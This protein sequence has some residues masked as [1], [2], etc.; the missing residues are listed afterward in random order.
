MPSVIPGFEHDV[1]I[2]YR[3]HDNRNGWV[4]HFAKALQEELATIVKEPVSVYLDTNPHDGLQGNHHVDKS[5]STHLNSAIFIPILSHT[6]CDPKSFAWN[7]EF[8]PFCNACQAG[9]YGIDV[10]LKNRNVAS[11]VLPVQVHDLSPSDQRLFESQTGGA[12]R[13]IDFIFRS[14][15]VNR[16][17]SPDDARPENVSHILYRDQVN[18]TAN[19][20]E[21]LLL[22]MAE[23]PASHTS[24]GSTSGEEKQT[25]EPKSSLWREVKR[26][27][28]LR[29]VPVYVASA[30]VV[31][32]LCRV[33]NPLLQFEERTFDIIT[34]MLSAGFVVAILLAWFF[35][36]S[37]R[38][39]I[40]I[41]SPDAKKNPFGSRRRKPMTSRQFVVILLG[42]FFLQYLYYHFF[43][44]ATA[45]HTINDNG[46]NMIAIAV[47]PF[48]SRTQEADTRYVAEGMTEDIINRLTVIEELAVTIPKRV[49][50]YQGSLVS[51]ENAARELDVAVLITGSVERQGGQLVI[52]VKMIDQKNTFLWGNTFYRL[53]DEIMGVQSEV[54]QQV[55]NQLK[56]ELN[57]M[58]VFR[59]NQKVTESP[60]AYEYFLRARSYYLKY[61][62]HAN[63][64]AIFFYKQAIRY[65]TRYARAYAG[66]ADAYAQIAGRFAGAPYWNDSSLAA[67]TKALSLDSTLSDVHKALGT[68]YNYRDEYLKALPFLLKAVELNPSN[69]QAIGNLGTNYMLRGDLATALYWQKRG[70]GLDVKNWIPYQL[71]G[72]TYRL[73]GDFSNAERWLLKSLELNSQQHDTYEM[74]AYTYVVQGRRQ[75]ALDLIPRVLQIDSRDT[76]VLEAAGLIAHFAGDLTQ[77]KRYFSQ[78]IEKN[79]GYKDDRMTISPLGLG[80]ILL[81]EGNEIDAEILLLR[82]QENFLTEIRQGSRFYEPPFYLACIHAVRN[83][84]KSA[85]GWLKKAI[86][87]NWLDYTRVT[88]GP[89]F[90]NLQSDPEL[91]ALVRQVRQKSDSIRAR[92]NSVPLPPQR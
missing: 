62:P 19:A 51:V 23:P 60:T 74:L 92:A 70:A 18:K 88:H 30:L 20:I 11:R 63:D 50:P 72:W 59:L 76:R 41:G 10:R 4:T 34:W 69:E 67:A 80:Q 77:A 32:Q 86:E 47:L 25:S 21:Q 24:T 26:R 46:K 15:G 55:A 40:R 35:E 14:T 64:S 29:I 89:Y 53:A 73:L 39:I 8:L 6:Y 31:L 43:G 79:A 44:P 1:F 82:A 7:N 90:K 87:F 3:Q 22:A 27:D 48:E 78:S 28:V 49:R 37:P 81:Q 16:P 36:F 42:V 13:S 56:L 66:L 58:E 68:A 17:L 12:L 52:R 57:D 5:L 33:L 91:Q 65:D 45:L 38:G 61:Q 2:S 83:D 84:S 75:S 54:A 9:P 71:V 85:V